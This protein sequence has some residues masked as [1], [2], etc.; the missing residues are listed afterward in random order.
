MKIEDSYNDNRSFDV[1]GITGSVSKYIKEDVS[2]PYFVL[3]ATEECPVPLNRLQVLP[4]LFGTTQI[5]SGISTA[6][7]VTIYYKA[8]GK[9]IKLGKLAARQVKSF[10]RLFEGNIIRGMYDASTPLEGDMLYV[11][12]D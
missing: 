10:L 5:V 2:Y 3:E 1:D 7:P 12:S 9:V 8:E 6:T 11:L 4:N